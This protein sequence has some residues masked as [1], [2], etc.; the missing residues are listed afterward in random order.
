MKAQIK[1]FL[2]TVAVTVSFLLVFAMLMQLTSMIFMPKKDKS[3][4]GMID[5][6]SSGFK[7]EPDN[8]LDVFL[9]GNSDL[10][11]GIIPMDFW[12]DYG[13]TSFVCGLPAQTGAAALVKLRK[14]LKKQTPKVVVIET[15]MLLGIENENTKGRYLKRF[16][17]KTKEIFWEF[18]DSNY[19]DGLGTG[20]SYKFPIVR[21]HSRWDEL[22]MNDIKEPMNS[23]NFAGKGHIVSVDTKPYLGGFDYMAKTDDRAKMSKRQS[24]CLKRM[25]EICK[26]RNIAVVLLEL[27]SATSWSY[28]KHNTIADIAKENNIP[29]VDYNIDNFAQ[30]NFNWETDTKDGGDHLN[31]YGAEKITRH[32]GEF[33]QSNYELVNRKEDA[34]YDHWN[35]DT[36]R[37]ENIKIEALEKENK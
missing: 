30:T 4:D 33:L 2:K 25:L 31:I 19:N 15:D 3:E 13:F 5:Y 28:A 23:Y 18:D 20:I 29:F 32:F 34:A 9:I 26:D 27:P 7:G 37:F 21:Y 17:N 35:S 8:T 22:T 6:I 16:L 24:K 11:R 1:Y 10:Y 14:A 12:K 36:K